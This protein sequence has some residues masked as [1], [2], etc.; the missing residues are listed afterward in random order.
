MI[1]Q[2]QSIEYQNKHFKHFSKPVLLILQIPFFHI[3]F[4]L[5]AKLNKI[6]FY[7]RQSQIEIIKV[8]KIKL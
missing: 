2:F 3:T 7:D 6:F 1:N 5:I 8:T 4:A